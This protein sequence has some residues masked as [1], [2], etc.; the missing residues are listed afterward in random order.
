MTGLT[1]NREQ[2]YCIRLRSCYSVLV[3]TQIKKAIKDAKQPWGVGWSSLTADMRKSLICA[4][5]LGQFA[6]MDT[7]E[8]TVERRAELLTKWQGLA[9]EVLQSEF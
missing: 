4:C 7:S 9:D 2:S 6:L 1:N 5:L 8:L 3:S